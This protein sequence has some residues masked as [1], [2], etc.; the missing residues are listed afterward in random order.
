MREVLH[1]LSNPVAAL[2]ANLIWLVDALGATPPLP[3]A[4]LLSAAQESLSAVDQLRL[5]IRAFRAENIQAVAQTFDAGR[6]IAVGIELARPGVGERLTVQLDTLP[7]LLVP[8]D[9]LVL[10][11]LVAN[12]LL[13]GGA[14][15]A[16]LSLTA[17]V[18]ASE[19]WIEVTVEAAAPPLNP[20]NAKAT[21]ELVAQLHARL[22][23]SAH[24]A[25]SSARLT[26]PLRR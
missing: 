25:R 2:Q 6:A 23:A 19:A 16:P 22:T 14:A 24:L 10:S 7:A 5:R 1:D 15:G 12:L 17:G 11:Q 20:E 26:L 21:A 9:P 4:E 13:D 18:G 8:G 3:A